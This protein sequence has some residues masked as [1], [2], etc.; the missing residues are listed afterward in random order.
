MLNPYNSYKILDTI[1]YI[2][3]NYELLRN[4]TG[5][6]LLNSL[7]PS[8]IFSIFSIQKEIPPSNENVM[9]STIKKIAYFLI[10]LIKSKQSLPFIL[11]SEF[12]SNL[13][14]TLPF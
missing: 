11:Q 14:L 3:S 7:F 10:K 5:N 8:K 13:R 6:I 4:I 12:S 1:F 9:H 2:L